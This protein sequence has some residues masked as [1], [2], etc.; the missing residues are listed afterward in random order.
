[1]K[2]CLW[3]FVCIGLLSCASFDGI[4][5]GA[6]ITY[7]TPTNVPNSNANWSAVNGAYNQNFGIAFTTGNS[8]PFDIDWIKLGLNTSGVASGSASLT[9]ALRNTNNTTAY[10]A[11]ASTTEYAKDT[12]TFSM[13]TTTSTA[14]ELNLTSVQLPNISAYSM[15]SNTTYALILYAPSVNIGMG[16]TSG[17]ANGTTNNQYT[18]SSGFTMLDTFRNN[19][20]NYSNNAN[21]FPTLAISFGATTTPPGAVPEPTTLGI[22]A[23]AISGGMLRRFR[24]RVQG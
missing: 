1:M 5:S 7:I 20:A 18:V 12:V 21:S 3:F 24:K 19:T 6:A 15:A 9:I 14:F 17:F 13:P 11:V 2:L 16:R 8:G 10:S 4:A 23:L 22:W